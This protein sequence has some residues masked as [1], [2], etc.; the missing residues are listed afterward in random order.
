MPPPGESKKGISGRPPVAINPYQS[1]REPAGQRR[2]PRVFTAARRSGQ[3][4]LLVFP[5][6]FLVLGGPAVG[7]LAAHLL[8]PG[9]AAGLWAASLAGAAI[10]IASV[11]A[12]LNLAA[13]WGYRQMARKLARL[14]REDGVD[15]DAC[16]GR[17]VELGVAVEARVYH[18]GM[19]NWDIGFLFPGG[20]RLVY[21]GDQAVFSIHRD[22]VQRITRGPSGIERLM[23][24]NIYVHWR[25]MEDHRLD[26]FS[27][28][29]AEGML[30]RR[31]SEANSLEAELRR[32]QSGESPSAAS[33]PATWAFSPEP[34]FLDVPSRSQRTHLLFSI[35]AASTGLIIGL[36]L[37]GV[38]IRQHLAGTQWMPS[39]LAAGLGSVALGL[40]ALT[41][42]ILSPRGVRTALRAT[43]IDS[44]RNGEPV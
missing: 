1:P 25:S 40:A 31:R 5:I 30:H 4:A 42:L 20:E 24:D 13:G 33:L 15:V 37:L 38:D 36:G 29:P 9:S 16:G 3:L 41:T 17:F 35:G 43:T 12:W 14:W 27:L 18:G 23:P 11:P 7:S 39:P 34:S 19:T 32:W 10:A 22:Q 2:G 28:A 44:S 26:G 6:V 21:L 8:A